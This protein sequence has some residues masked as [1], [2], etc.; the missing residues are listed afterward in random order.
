M[1]MRWSCVLLLWCAAPA[2]AQDPR[3]AARFPAAIATRLESVIDSAS[4]EGLPGEPLVLRAL[5][6]AAKNAPAPVIVDVVERLHVALRAART[7]LGSSTPAEL[8]TAAAAIQAGVPEAKLVEL[9]T[10]RAGMSVTA[11]LGAYLDLVA[12]GAAADRA[13]D[14][15]TELARRQARDVEFIRLK[16]EDLDHKLPPLPRPRGE[17][18]GQGHS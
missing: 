11:P 4:R 18:P 2:A 3:I 10:L 1:S 15:V 13:W 17:I 9:H 8:T 16:P 14:R 5:E 6:G 12:R 7:A